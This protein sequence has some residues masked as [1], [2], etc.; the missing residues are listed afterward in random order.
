MT[1]QPRSILILY[2]SQSGNSEELAEQ[3]GKAC[4]AHG[5]NPS[6]KAMDEI[7]ITDL[8]TQHKTFLTRAVGAAR[9]ERLDDYVIRHLID[10]DDIDYEAN[11]DLLYKLAGQVVSHIKG[12]LHTPEDQENVC[13]CQLQI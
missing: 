12:Y 3:A 7:Q 4:S 9:E 2:G 11:A 13:L 1:S 10:K 8:R 5:L 6:V